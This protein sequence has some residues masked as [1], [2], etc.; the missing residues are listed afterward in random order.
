MSETTTKRGRP[1]RR[2]YDRD[3]QVAF[4]C[5]K[6]REIK[7]ETEF[8]RSKKAWRGRRTEC[9]S[10]ERERTYRRRRAKKEAG[11]PDPWSNNR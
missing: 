6:C 9:K 11:H 7:V 8:S 5:S 2:T 3:G 10:C 1:H 4:A